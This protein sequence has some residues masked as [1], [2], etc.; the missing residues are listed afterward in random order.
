M[1]QIFMIPL[2]I[3][4]TIGQA[5]IR[6]EPVEDFFRPELKKAEILFRLSHWN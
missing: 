4:K 1:T 6:P 2:Q 3:V 5:I